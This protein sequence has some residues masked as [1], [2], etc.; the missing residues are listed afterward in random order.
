[1]PP[2]KFTR[3]QLRVADIHDSD[4]T[5]QT[6]A[7]IGEHATPAV[8][9]EAKI[10]DDDDLN[11]D[12]RDQ[13][14]KDSPIDNDIGY[15]RSPNTY[16]HRLDV[17]TQNRLMLEMLLE[18]QAQWKAEQKLERER[19]AA[20]QERMAATR[21]QWAAE[22]AE[23]AERS[24]TGPRPRIYKTVDP[25]R[26][27]GGAKE[28]DRFLDALHSNFN[29][30]GYLFPRSGP[31]HVKYAI[32]L[33]DACSNHQNPALRQTAM[34]DPSEW[35]GDLSAESG[36]CLQD[37][38]LFSPEIAKDYGDKD[39]RRVAVITLMQEY[40]QLTQESVRAYE[41]RV[42]ANCRQAG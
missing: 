13:G 30:H 22:R 18:N 25:V 38:D 7:S 8:L 21:A 17:A 1:M 6:A 39:R 42:K 31:D 27:C 35:A 28:L 41:N 32:S 3:T 5:L 12:L 2:K 26:Y 11:D 10:D 9:P 29:S 34:T 36:R 37:F 33:L 19:M 15:L 14:D 23:L 20:E 4:D 40:I 24:I 16:E